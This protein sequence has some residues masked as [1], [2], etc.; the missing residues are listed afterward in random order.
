MDKIRKLM[1]NLKEFFKPTDIYLS[2]RPLILVYACCGVI[3]IRLAGKKGNRKL[4]VISWGI[5]TTLV[6]IAIFG[7]SFIVTITRNENFATFIFRTDVST[8]SGILQLCVSFFAMAITYCCSYLKRYKLIETIE[9]LAKIDEKLY[10]MNV[11]LNYKKKFQTNLICLSFNKVIFVVYVVLSIAVL[12]SSNE[13][14]SLFGWIAYFLPHL[15][16]S[17]VVLIFTCMAKEI[18]Y[19]FAKLNQVIFSILLI[20]VRRR[21]VCT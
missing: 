2:L 12:N 10:D 20:I 4:Q 8:I 21:C 1:K 13:S 7:V 5:L 14:P 9:A 15:I 19:R 16:V 6:H 17:V 18:G 11:D 3:S